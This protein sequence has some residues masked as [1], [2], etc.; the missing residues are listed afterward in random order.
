MAGEPRKAS[1]LAATGQLPPREHAAEA[2]PPQE[3]LPRTHDGHRRG[4]HVLGAILP[5][6]LARSGVGFVQS[7]E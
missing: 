7:L 2:K 1:A 4:P 5:I 6:V 3:E